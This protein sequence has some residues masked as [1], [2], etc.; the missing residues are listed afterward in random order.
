MNLP[1]PSGFSTRVEKLQGVEATGS[2]QLRDKPIE[3]TE[4]GSDLKAR[5]VSARGAGLYSRSPHHREN[6]RP[7]TR[8]SIA[9]ACTVQFRNGSWGESSGLVDE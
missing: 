2:A 6:E 8:V 9:S 7:I 3:C 1:C 5:A 4:V